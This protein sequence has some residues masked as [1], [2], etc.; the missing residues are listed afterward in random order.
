[1][2]L[3]E[4]WALLGRDSNR[5]IATIKGLPRSERVPASKKILD[6]AKRMAAKTSAQYHPDVGGDP[7][8]FKEIWEA[9]GVIENHTIEFESQMNSFEK[10][11]EEK[12]KK[13]NFIEIKKW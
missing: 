8:K 13:N 5:V 2:T 12:R 3:S 6:K 9:L 11:M 4:A 1:M 7:I 10:K